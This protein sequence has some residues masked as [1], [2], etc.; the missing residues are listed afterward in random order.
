MITIK[1]A[2]LPDGSATLGKLSM[3]GFECCTLENPWQANQARV[4]CIT[5]GVYTLRMRPSPIVERTSG[6]AFSVGW[7][8]TNVQGR[9]FIMIHP[10]NWQKDT[11]GCILPGRYFSWN[12]SH[13]PMVTASRDT[14]A[15]LM[16]ALSGRDEW[17]LDVRCNTAEWP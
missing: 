3:D 17:T 15:G 9:T 4:S 13:G 16:E 6:G 1:R 7:E 5:E 11:A 2:Y 12:A 10:G 14:F 8:V